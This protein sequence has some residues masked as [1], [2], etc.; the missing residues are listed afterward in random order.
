MKVESI[1]FDFS[2][3][4]STV[5]LRIPDGE[6]V[7]TA[8]CGEWIEGIMAAGSPGPRPVAA[9]AV[10]TAADTFALTLRYYETPF[11]ETYSFHFDGNNLLLKGAVNVAFGP[12]EYPEVKGRLA[13]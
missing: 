5:K 11:Y 7:I 2:A 9:S 10:W 3:G 4:G 13:P 8:G 12:K 6:Q 1:R